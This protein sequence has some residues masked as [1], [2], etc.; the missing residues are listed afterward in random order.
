MPISWRKYIVRNAVAFY[1]RVISRS[2]SGT[3]ANEG[4]PHAFTVATE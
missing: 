1:L 2:Y 4:Y 3:V